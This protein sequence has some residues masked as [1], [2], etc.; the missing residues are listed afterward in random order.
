MTIR[1]VIGDCSF[2][3]TSGDGDVRGASW[4]TRKRT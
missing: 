1:I 4:K 2:D 3:A